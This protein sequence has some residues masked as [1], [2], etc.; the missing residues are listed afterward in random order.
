[1]FNK[2]VHS[3]T[4]VVLACGPGNMMDDMEAAMV[5]AYGIGEDKVS[6]SRLEHLKKV[7]RGGR[8]VWAKR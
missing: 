1:M 5:E 7:S 6:T 4:L 8:Q 2:F 3:E